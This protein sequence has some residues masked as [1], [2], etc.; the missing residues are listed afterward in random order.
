MLVIV[1]AGCSRST[2]PIFA[3]IDPPLVWPAPPDPPRIRY[4]GTLSRTADLHGPQSA[5]ARMNWLVTGRKVDHRLV[6]PKDVAV[7]ADR[8]Y[9]ADPGQRAVMMFDLARRRTAMIGSGNVLAFPT[10]V[11]AGDGR[12]FVSDA[13]RAV[14]AVFTDEGQYV[15]VWGKEQ[16]D[17]PAGLCWCPTNRRLYVVDVAGHCVR[18]FDDRGKPV[19]RF[20]ERGSGPGQFNLPQSIAFNE[21][22]G[23][24]VTDSMNARIQRFAL[25]G[26]FL[27]GFG[28]KGNAAGQLSLPKGLACDADG[29]IY[30]VD[31]NFENVQIFDPAGRLLLAFGGEG[32]RPGKFWL[33]QGMFI[34]RRDRLWLADTY[35]R[36]VQV[37]QYLSGKDQVR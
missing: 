1:A 12:V 37:F 25:D 6:A 9:V 16:F 10:H 28:K 32:R 21:K 2:P 5:A 31:T 14:V 15:T 33:P 4:V 13:E 23:L 7:A 35:N 34:D 8:V 11:A 30:V 29:H 3:P 24:L 20:G 27:E 36:R 18:V 26:R 17:R 19:N 22:L